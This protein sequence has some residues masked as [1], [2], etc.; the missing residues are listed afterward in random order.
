[1]LNDITQ[2]NVIYQAGDEQQN[3]RVGGG[4]LSR[5]SVVAA[6]VM[7]SQGDDVMSDLARR[8]QE[9]RAKTD[10]VRSCFYVSVVYCDGVLCDAFGMK[11][12]CDMLYETYDKGYH[13]VFGQSK[14]SKCR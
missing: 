14:C 11:T 13:A 1:V 3:A 4:T 12:C 8:L 2:C 5:S 7:N 9:R 6:A 10:Q